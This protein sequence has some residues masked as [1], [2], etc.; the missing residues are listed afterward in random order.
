MY[1]DF[2]LIRSFL[3]KIEEDI[4]AETT[5]ITS[6]RRLLKHTWWALRNWAIY[7]YYF[8]D[9][10]ELS[11]DTY[12]SI[13]CSDLDIMQKALKSKADSFTCRYGWIVACKMP[14]ITKSWRLL[15]VMV[16]NC[17]IVIFRIVLLATT[18][19]LFN[20]SEFWPQETR[21]SRKWASNQWIPLCGFV[22]HGP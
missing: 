14:T 18:N 8:F 10:E 15:Q 5:S 11:S 20:G 4:F 17:F 22:R 1:I 19:F 3:P 7:Y 12:T 6:A 16:T 2:N 21:V 13:L 9:K